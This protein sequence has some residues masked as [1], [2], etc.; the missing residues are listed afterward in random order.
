MRARVNMKAPSRGAGRSRR[1]ESI[2]PIGRARAARARL[3]APQIAQPNS[4][5]TPRARLAPPATSQ[6]NE[7][8]PTTELWAD[9]DSSWDIGAAEATETTAIAAIRANAK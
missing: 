5:A 2:E 4:V 8:A 6:A 1:D 9:T 3:P 7:A